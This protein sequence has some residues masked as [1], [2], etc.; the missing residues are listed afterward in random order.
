MKGKSFLARRGAVR[1]SCEVPN[2]PTCSAK[3]FWQTCSPPPRAVGRAIPLWSGAGGGYL[4]RTGFT[5]QC[6]GG[7]L[8]R[9]GTTP[10]QV[11]GLFLPRGADLLVA[12][13][14]IAR[15]GAAWLPFDAET[16]MKRIQTCLQSAKA[17]GLVTCRDWLPR[18]AHSPLPVLALEDLLAEENPAKPGVA[19]RP[20]DPAYV[21]YTSGSTGEPKGIVI[22]Q[23][24]ICHLLRSENE[25]LGVRETTWF[26]KDSRWRSTCLSRKSGS[27]IWWARR[28]GLRRPRVGDPDCWRNPCS[29][30][31]SPSC[32]RC[33]RSLA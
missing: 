4:R 17:S 14:G 33:R 6:D 29:G 22:S 32:T 28:F 18:F 10:G 19:A 27:P 11:L 5:Q 2:V 21:I 30:N 1:R 9:R 25:V 12:Q 20:P 3:R 23:R 31:A 7:R 26:I 15:C 8:E 16:P 24:S 13:A